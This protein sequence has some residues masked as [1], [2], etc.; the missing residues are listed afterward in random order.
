MLYQ[1]YCSSKKQLPRDRP[2]LYSP[3]ILKMSAYNSKYNF[4][5]YMNREY[6]FNRDKMACRCC[7]RELLY[8]EQRECHHVYPKLPL[9]QANKVPNLAWVCIEC[10]KQIHGK[11]IPPSTEAK[12]KRKIISFREKLNN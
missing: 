9:N 3:D 8:A 12:I 6:A 7:K 4:E 2:A 11:E 10:H 5:Y 1:K